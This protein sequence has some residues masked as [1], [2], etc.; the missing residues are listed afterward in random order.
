M[1]IIIISAMFPPVRTGTSNYSKNIA[2]AFYKKGHDVTVVTLKNKEKG[3]DLFPYEVIRLLCIH[4]NIKNYFKHF[5]ISSLFPKNYFFMFKIVKKKK[6]D[7]TL[8]VNHYLDIAFPAIMSA[9]KFKIPLVISVGTQ[10]QSLNPIR[11]KILNILDS[12]ICGKLIFPFCKNIIAWD[13]E[14]KR[15]INKVHNK[16]FMEKI[17]IIPF[18]ANGNIEIYQQHSHSYLLHNQILGVGSIIGQ[19]NYIFQVETFKELIKI[20]PDLKLKIIGHIYN[21][22]AFLL[23]KQYGLND[24]I[25]FMGEQPHEVVIK[26]MMNSDL[27]WM[28]LDGEY[29]GL[30]TSN[31]EAMLLGIPIISNIS[32][33]LFGIDSLKDMHNFI[34]TDGENI[35][36]ILKKIILLYN[37]KNLRLKIGEMGKLF[38]NQRMNWDVVVEK[39][40]SLFLSLNNKKNC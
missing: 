22:N 21:R 35:E 12:F 39:M 38:V 18:G 40:E 24:K 17:V 3:K 4:I 32:E 25:V 6:P 8:L 36:L 19:R 20:F 10:L 16:R 9:R 29:K 23:T 13:E 33:N 28:M 2:D 27:H 30:G 5:R 14:I 1:N 34:Y 37:S 26:E 7:I 31:L 15:Y 11:N